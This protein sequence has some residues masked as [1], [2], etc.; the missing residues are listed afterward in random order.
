MVVAL[1]RKVIVYVEPVGLPTA[2]GRK[3]KAERNL[4][5]IRLIVY[6]PKIA[7]AI[8]GQAIRIT[9]AGHFHNRCIAARSQHLLDCIVAVIREIDVGAAV[10]C[11]ACWPAKTAAECNGGVVGACLGNLLD[12]IIAGIGNIKVSASVERD[13]RWIAESGDA[14]L[15]SS[16]SRYRN[17]PHCSA[18]GL[19]A[20]EDVSAAVQRNAAGSVETAGKDAE[21]GVSS[22]LENLFHCIGVGI[23]NIDISVAIDRYARQPADGKAKRTAKILLKSVGLAHCTPMP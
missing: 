13:A 6:N 10:H 22:R 12:R 21:G 14:Q 4:L 9:D 2:S 7:A 15:S 23:G 11:D 5:K 1:N 18:T 3:R 20:D 19:I 17:L 16:R 8:K